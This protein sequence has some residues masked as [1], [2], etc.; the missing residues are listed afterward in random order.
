M[1]VN[2]QT[3]TLFP[4]YDLKERELRNVSML[5]R[6]LELVPTLAGDLFG[7]IGVYVG[8]RPKAR[9]LTEVT[10][11]DF[12]N[13]R[14]D[15]FIEIKNWRALVEAK[16]DSNSL[17]ADQVRRYIEI[18]KHH[19]LSAVITISNEMVARPDYHPCCKLSKSEERRLSLYHLSWQLIFTRLCLWAEREESLDSEQVELLADFRDFL[20]SKSS[21]LNRFDRMSGYWKPLLDD[22]KRLPTSER[23]LLS[24]ENV[25]GVVRDWFFE[26]R[27]ISLKLS[28]QLKVPV[29]VLIPKKYRGGNK[30]ED[31]L[32]ASVRE[33]TQHLHLETILHIPNAAAGLQLRAD[34]A[35]QQIEASMKLKA[36]RNSHTTKGRV[37]W[38]KRMLKNVNED[39]LD[40]TSVELRWVGKLDP[41]IFPLGEF[42]NW[43]KMPDVFPPSAVSSF[44]IRMISDN[45]RLFQSPTGFIRELEHLALVFY[46]QIGENLKK[47]VPPPPKIDETL[48]QEADPVMDH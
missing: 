19:G 34:L 8:K 29:Q 18:A 14:P 3:P 26:E 42:L 40:V 32:E 48:R 10:F 33:L 4:A 6:A 28:E 27:D 39:C 43:K 25:R 22:V 23:L 13:E 36:T 46:L 47:W 30:A 21:G 41:L 45:A 15:G 37:G 20:K 5:F 38:L 35:K 7:E 24:N 31:R 2:Y 16:C 17:D 9:Y 1:L 11:E 44:E 12:E